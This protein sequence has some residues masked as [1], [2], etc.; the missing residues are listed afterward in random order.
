MTAILSSPSAAGDGRGSDDDEALVS[1]GDV[2]VACDSEV[3]SLLEADAGNAA[4]DELA[5]RLDDMDADESLRLF[6]VGA[7]C[8]GGNFCHGGLFG[9]RPRNFKG[10]VSP[11]CWSRRRSIRFGRVSCLARLRGIDARQRLA[12]ARKNVERANSGQH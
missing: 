10:G 4:A 6:A 5:D 3:A 1:D 12:M 7:A 11:N 9:P 8:D 2:N